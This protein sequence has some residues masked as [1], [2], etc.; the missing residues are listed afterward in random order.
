MAQSVR[1]W[2][3]HV[4]VHASVVPISNVGNGSHVNQ[5]WCG[6]VE[7]H[8]GA[9]EGDFDVGDV[10]SVK[11]GDDVGDERI[12]E[13]CQIVWDLLAIDWAIWP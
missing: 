7:E 2:I 9:E 11:L 12:V 13:C 4:L 10:D 1:R 6:V 3:C 8:N 5:S